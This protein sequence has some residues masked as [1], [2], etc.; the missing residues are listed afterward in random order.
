MRNGRAVLAKNGRPIITAYTPPE[1]DAYEAH[2]AKFA[3]YAANQCPEWGPSVLAPKA[4]VRIQMHFV[5]RFWRADWD[6]LAKGVA[7]A[8]AN[9]E[10]FFFNDNR[11]TEAMISVRTDKHDRPR[12]EVCVEPATVDLKIPLWAQVALEQGWSPPSDEGE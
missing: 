12:V 3:G 5:R 6:N 9:T 8:M 10:R 7:D 1:T 4:P 11:I 2:V